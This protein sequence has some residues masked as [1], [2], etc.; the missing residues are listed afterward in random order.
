M[1]L[2]PT[3]ASPLDNQGSVLKNSLLTWSTVPGATSYSLEV[4]TDNLFASVIYS[5]SVSSASANIV[6]PTYDTWFYWRVKAKS[7]IANDS[8]SWTAGRRFKTILQ[9]P[10]LNAPVT[11]TKT[12]PTADIVEWYAVTGATTYNVQISLNSDM[13]SPAVNV[14]GIGALTYSYSGLLEGRKYYWRV[15]ASNADGTSLWSDLWNFSTAIAPPVLV[16]PANN[17]VGQPLSI[18]FTWNAVVGATTYDVQVSTEADFASLV[19]DYKNISGTSYVHAENF[20]SNYTNYYWRVR[21][22]SSSGPG[23]W[24]S[25]FTFRTI[26]ARPR[27]IT[28][29]NNTK[30]VLLTGDLTWANQP[31][32]KYYQ[33]EVA[34]DQFFTEIVLTQDSMTTLKYH[35]SEL[36]FN[37]QYFW[38]VRAMNDEGKTIYSDAWTFTTTIPVPLLTAP[39]NNG[40]EIATTGDMTWVAVPGA[41]SYVVHVAEDAAFQNRVVTAVCSTNTYN[42]TLNQ[43]KNYYWKVHAIFGADLRSEWS[44]TWEFIT[45]NSIGEVTLA[46]PAN[47]ALSVP[48]KGTLTWNAP[49]GTVTSYKLQISTLSNFSTLEKEELALTGT[50]YS[51]ELAKATTYYWRVRATNLQQD[52]LHQ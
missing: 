19:G 49:I 17:A 5:T 15:S 52:N 16:T 21:G 47:N 11:N 37:T 9:S 4:A 10:S 32:S 51:Y 45:K 24:S 6:M 29:E 1:L 23:L 50:S 26:M 40:T 36:A 43:N 18:S 44:D 28:P 8:S 27:L 7:A 46:T 38:H 48:S 42:Y 20:F 13:S 22:V 41:V 34:T 2:T 12:M 3:L 14:T 35:Y 39:A 25:P 31:G 33:I 30:N